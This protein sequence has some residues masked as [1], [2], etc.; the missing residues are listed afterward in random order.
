MVSLIRYYFRIKAWMTFIFIPY[1]LYTFNILYICISAEVLLVNQTVNTLLWIQ[2][3]VNVANICR[4]TF[5]FAWIYCYIWVN[6]LLY[7]REYTFIFAWIYFYI[8]RY[9]LLYLSEYT[10]IFA[11]FLYLGFQNFIF[12]IRL[13]KL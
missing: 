9:I 4:C 5:I 10:F 1:V 13:K 12:I 6:I 3:L 11:Y 2:S 7:L 8:C